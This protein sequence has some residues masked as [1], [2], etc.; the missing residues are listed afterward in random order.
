MQVDVGVV[1]E[2]ECNL[3]RW[4]FIEI[5]LEI[6]PPLIKFFSLRVRV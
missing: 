3:I 5:F 2:S 1:S 6:K 4:R